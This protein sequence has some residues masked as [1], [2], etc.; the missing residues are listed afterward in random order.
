[1]KC[2]SVASS[3][4]ASV[5]TTFAAAAALSLTLSACGDDGASADNVEHGDSHKQE[6]VSSSADD[7]SSSSVEKD[8]EESSSSSAKEE[9]AKARA[10]T[11]DDLTAKN[12]SMGT[13]FGSNVYLA[14]GAKKGVFSL[15]IPDTAWVA[16][17]SDFK[18]GVIKFGMDMQ[19]AG[20]SG[21]SV[22]A[23]DSLNAL[24]EKGTTIKVIVN[25]D[26]ELQYSLNDGDMKNLESVNVM[27]DENVLSDGTELDGRSLTC[28]SEDS[29]IVYN[30]YD[31]RYVVKYGKSSWEA[32]YYDIQRGHLL[33]LPTYYPESA[34]AL[35]TMVLDSVNMRDV[36]TRETMPC[37]SA[38]NDY[39]AVAY[40]DL[41]SD[42]VSTDKDY[43]WTMSLKNDGNFSV[44][45][46]SG[47]NTVIN[48]SGVW[49]VYGD[50]LLLHNELCDKTL[51]KCLSSIMGVVG[52]FDKSG[53]S[54]EN[55]DVE[56]PTIPTSWK[57]PKYE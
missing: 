50:V 39:K 57:K 4:V 14:R 38:K 17:R 19:N 9:E 37:K 32:G 20:W 12:Y 24:V 18:D 55:S 5:A 44:M 51:K 28:K 26:N 35:N 6:S 22:P 45:A 7:K 31:G 33:M 48:N 29:D 8:E 36:T 56:D 27:V 52:D 25:E 23:G 10:A 49:D 34:Y 43:S 21:A 40:G 11:L 47:G 2:F 15:W 53:F 16:I 42:W 54:L 41:A 1:M 30:F 3:K 13:L 46:K